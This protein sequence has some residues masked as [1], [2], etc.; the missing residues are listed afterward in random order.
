[1]ANPSASELKLI[2]VAASQ[3]D[4]LFRAKK[5]N[6][7]F[8]K[9]LIIYINSYKKSSFDYELGICAFNPSSN[10]LCRAHV[11]HDVY[12]S[13]TKARVFGFFLPNNPKEIWPPLSGQYSQDDFCSF[14][15]SP[16]IRQLVFYSINNPY[17]IIVLS[18]PKGLNLLV[19]IVYK[20][21]I[22]SVVVFD[23]DDEELGFYHL[24]NELLRV[25]AGDFFKAVPD[26]SIL[27]SVC[28][29]ALAQ[30]L[31]KF[32]DFTTASNVALAKKY[33]ALVIP[34]AKKISFFDVQVLPRDSL[35][36][37]FGLF[38]HE[39]VIG[40]IGTNREHKGLQILCE[41]LS[42]FSDFDICLLKI[43]A[44][45]NSIY[46]ERICNHLRVINVPYILYENLVEVLSLLDCVV[47]IQGVDNIS[48]DYQMPAK[49][50]DAL[51]MSVPVICKET[52]A[53]R[54][55]IENGVLIKYEDETFFSVLK[56]IK[57]DEEF[58]LNQARHARNYFEEFLST[59]SVANLIKN[60]L[61]DVKSNK[62]RKEV[63]SI[64]G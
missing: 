33:D 13:F 18:K 28:W 12:S 2:E 16:I 3:F 31:C 57:S 53:T 14:S 26:L 11:L 22:G 7:N 24:D 19:A 35:K 36:A 38:D 56:K 45:V 32:F 60:K 21:I 58:L 52:A 54:T 37:K 63:Q 39:Y 23:I 43:D 61:L 17:R 49:I 20:L 15:D 55:L 6:E 30:K 51:A 62:L 1:M 40:F 42:N 25:L 29:T 64:I 50:T 4:F 44:K 59:E 48:S 10:S 34:H 41:K 8:S 27:N 47:L 9:D 46:S 5:L